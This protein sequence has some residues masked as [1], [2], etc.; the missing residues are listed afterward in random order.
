MGINILILADI[1]LIVYMLLVHPSGD[2][3]SYF[4]IFDVI[5]CA[6]LLF[7]W[8]YK[9]QKVEQRG[10][11]FKHNVI[12]LIATIPFELILPVYFMAFRFLLLLRLFKLSGILEKYFENIHRFIESTKFDKIVTWILFVVIVF[13]FA[14]YIFDESLGLFDSLWY[15]V[16][17]LTTVGYGDIM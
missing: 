6:I 13:T 12:F 4:L 5:V 14:I 2:L 9:F 11:F 8:F 3:L 10:A 15:V 16:V 1:A 17:T 7:D